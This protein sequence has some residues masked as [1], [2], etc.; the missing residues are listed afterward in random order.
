MAKLGTANISIMDVRNI[1][2]FPSTDLGTLCTCN[3]INPWSKWKPIHCANTLTLNNELL[4]RN[5][6]GIEILEANNPGM[7]VN[8]IKQ[9]GNLGYKYNKPWGGAFSPYRLGDFRNYYHNAL[10]PVSAFYD[11][12]DEVHVGGITSSNHG[13]YEVVIEGMSVPA[14]PNGDSDYLTKEM[15][16][17]FTDSSGDKIRLTKGVYFTDGTNDCWYS[18][19]AYYWTT[20]FQRFRGKQVEAYE[21]YTN[22]IRTPNDLWVADA[23]DRFYALPEPYHTISVDNR[24]PA[25][26][27]KVLVVCN[28]KYSTDRRSVFYTLQFSA[29]GEIYRGGTISNIH[30]RIAKDLKGI[31][32][33][34]TKKIA[35]SLTIQDETESSIYT[36]T[37]RNINADSV[38]VLVYYDNVIQYTTTPF[39]DVTDPE[40]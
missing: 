34:D 24:V 11:D 31:N 30:I 40:V 36:G 38:Y 29:V 12:G 28:P 9:N 10:L 1:L 27:K 14:F 6:Y 16:Y 2:G 32:M 37:L 3:N 7:L 39:M 20:E 23:K 22:A 8:L 26:S 5:K 4:K 17:D 13:S 21:F 15:I 35:D 33:I 25:G 18:G 19:K